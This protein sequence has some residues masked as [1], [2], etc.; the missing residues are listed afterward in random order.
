MTTCIS[1]I[2]LCLVALLLVHACAQDELSACTQSFKAFDVCTKTVREGVEASGAEVSIAEEALQ[3]CP[4]YE[5]LGD[6]FQ[7][8]QPCNY[9]TSPTSEYHNDAL[10]MQALVCRMHAYYGCSFSVEC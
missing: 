7:A 9:W 3:A 6:L 2:F 8:D 4:C 1:G 10:R 5:N